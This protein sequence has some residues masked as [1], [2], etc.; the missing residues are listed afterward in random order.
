MPVASGAN[1]WDRPGVPVRL[2]HPLDLE[3]WKKLLHTIGDGDTSFHDHA[4]AF[5]G[6]AAITD[7]L[8]SLLLKFS[9]E[10]R[11]SAVFAIRH[12]VIEGVWLDT[13]HNYFAIIFTEASGDPGDFVLINSFS[14]AKCIN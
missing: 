13:R 14:G 7:E 4:T 5:D 9:D 8:S 12:A 3:A 1:C 2:E 11:A 6:R 10:Q